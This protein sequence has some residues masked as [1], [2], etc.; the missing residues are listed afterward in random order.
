MGPVFSVH[1]I[2]LRLPGKDTKAFW[3]ACGSTPYVLASLLRKVGLLVVPWYTANLASISPCE[4]IAW[5]LQILRFLLLARWTKCGHACLFIVPFK[6]KILVSI[7]R[8]VV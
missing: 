1:W 7:P 8:P 4:S 6:E 3:S 5:W 2:R